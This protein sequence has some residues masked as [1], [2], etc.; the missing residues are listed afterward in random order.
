MSPSTGTSARR[1]AVLAHIGRQSVHRADGSLFGYELLFRDSSDAETANRHDDAAT[2]ATIVAA[3]SDFSPADLLGG[4]RGLVNLTRA[5]LTGERPV[6]FE[7]HEAILEVLPGVRVDDALVDGVRALADAGYLIALD[8]HSLG[9]PI[10]PLLPL[11]HLVK[12]NVLGRPW[13]EVAELGQQA[14]ERGLQAVAERVETGDV[15][16][17]CREAGYCLFQGYWFAR[18]TTLTAP[19]VGTSRAGALRL[20]AALADPAVGVSTLE[21]V[22]RADPGLTLRLLRAS[23]SAASGLTRE[24]SSIR[25]AIV[26]VGL[27][28]LRAWAALFAFAGSRPEMMT[29]ALARARAC[30]LLSEQL[31]GGRSDVA[32]TAGLLDGLAESMGQSG[33]ELLSQ[34]PALA[35]DL[36]G[37]L[38]GEP[39]TLTDILGRVTG[40]AGTPAPDQPGPRQAAGVRSDRG[41][42]GALGEIFLSAWSWATR[43]EAAVEQA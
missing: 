26:V 6:P 42:D 40:Y 17:R 13:P 39:G 20:L 16:E 10:A 14:G 3:F 28:K 31:D 35:P 34:L 11:A 43:T 2:T 24:V 23:N 18:P 1:T 41:A 38:V 27:S 9:G 25:D 8:D 33:E 22:L 37:A 12:V 15:V 7:P 32:F 36:A 29:A 19:S 5:F 30:E 21:A 4:S